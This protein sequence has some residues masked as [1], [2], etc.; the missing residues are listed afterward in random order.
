DIARELLGNDLPL[1]RCRELINSLPL[2]YRLGLESRPRAAAAAVAITVPILIGVRALIGEQ[3]A[4]ARLILFDL[5]DN[6][7]NRAI[8]LP[9]R[10]AETRETDAIRLA[11]GRRLRLFNSSRD[12]LIA[13]AVHQRRPMAEDVNGNWLFST[14][15]G[16]SGVID[17]FRWAA[18]G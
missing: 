2:R 3:A 10:A 12:S 11:D 1:A 7:S 16:D 6:Q 17:V 5:S 14:A 8:E 13:R 9:L 4:D 15:T 18:D